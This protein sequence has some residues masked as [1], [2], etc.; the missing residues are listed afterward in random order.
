VKEY[1][2]LFGPWGDKLW[3]GMPMHEL[4][5][6]IEGDWEE[7]ER[8]DELRFM[9]AVAHADNTE[10]MHTTAMSLTNNIVQDNLEGLRTEAGPASSKWIAPC[11]A[12]SGPGRTR[13]GC[14]PATSSSIAQI[15]STMNSSKLAPPSYRSATSF[16]LTL[17][18]TT[19]ARAVAV[20]SSRK[21]HG[22]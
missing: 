22:A 2:K 9:F 12:R 15:A 1:N 5:D 6:Q 18:E 11:S 10:T 17:A 19:H 20:R 21:C 14:A 4:I 7:G 16:S 3:C 13:S 8:R